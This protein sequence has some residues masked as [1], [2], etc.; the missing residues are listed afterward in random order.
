MGIL[1]FLTTKEIKEKVLEKIKILKKSQKNN[2]DIEHIYFGEGNFQNREGISVF[3]NVKG[4]HVIY[5]ERGK[6]MRHLV[7]DN[8]F[9]LMYWIFRDIIFSIASEY[10]K[11]NRIKNQDFR[12]VIFMKEIELF[13]IID[14]NLAKRCEIEID[15]ILKIAPYDD[16]TASQ[17]YS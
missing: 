3:S 8:L 7:T 16:S 10:E 15:E 13:S 14:T 11:K 1:R 2:L 6:E 12:R 4:Y 5:T 17:L 9:E